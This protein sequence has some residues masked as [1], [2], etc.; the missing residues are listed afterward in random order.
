MYFP[1]SNSN[2]ETQIHNLSAG[3][4]LGKA[5]PEDVSR[6]AKL[7]H[8]RGLLPLLRKELEEATV[9]LNGSKSS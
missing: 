5:K 1:K 2:P 3:I 4:V 8:D 9:I 7:A 6:I